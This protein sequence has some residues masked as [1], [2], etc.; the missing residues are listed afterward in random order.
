MQAHNATQNSRRDRVLLGAQIA[1][2]IRRDITRRH[3]GD[4][5]EL[6]SESV[7]ADELG[8][9]QRVV[10]DALRLL[11]QQGVIR[12]Q[13]GKRATVSTLRPVAIQDYFRLALE[14]DSSAAEEL[15]E[16]RLA[17]ETKAAAQAAERSSEDELSYV[18]GLL[19]K[20]ESLGETS[21]AERVRLDLDFH[22]GIVHASGNRFFVA[23][24]EALTDVLTEERRQGQELTEEI[25]KTHAE[26]NLEHRALLSAIRA[27]DSALAEQLMRS[28]L[29]RVRNRFRERSA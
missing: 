27:G 22:I 10:R 26:S 14:A 16:F 12:T 28:H 21:S 3:L 5:D 7:L 24:M 2:R 15:V 29:E 9:S 6:P 11:S 25:G 19:A 23:V 1:E 4:G 20:A 13:Q 8:V 18:E 17:L